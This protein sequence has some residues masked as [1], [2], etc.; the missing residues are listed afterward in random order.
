MDKYGVVH[1]ER[2][3]YYE[4]HMYCGEYR[5]VILGPV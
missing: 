2:Q 5:V 4:R 3:V 1:C